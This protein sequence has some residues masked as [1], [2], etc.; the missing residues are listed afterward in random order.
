MIHLTGKGGVADWAYLEGLGGVHLV[1][2]RAATAPT[3][4][5]HDK[6]WLDAFGASLGKKNGTEIEL[7]NMIPQDAHHLLDACHGSEENV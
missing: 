5:N 6:I 4:A 7:T 1:I 2:A 3:V